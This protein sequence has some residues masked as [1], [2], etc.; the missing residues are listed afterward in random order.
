MNFKKETGN[1]SNHNS[2]PK[3]EKNIPIPTDGR[4]KYPWNEMEIGDS[5]F[6]D[7]RSSTQVSAICGGW[8]RRNGRRFLVKKEGD[9]C[10][11]WRI[12]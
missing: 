2:I 3:I 12:E 1:L 9:G 4:K 8:G 5:M 11:A 7:G 6:F 10:R